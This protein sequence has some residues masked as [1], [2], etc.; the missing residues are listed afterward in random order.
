MERRELFTPFFL[1]EILTLY[2][3]KKRHIKFALDIIIIVIALR[4]LKKMEADKLN[5]EPFVCGRYSG[6]ND[7][8]E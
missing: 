7:E 6:G 2:T 8:Y 4:I 3:N 5:I 1:A